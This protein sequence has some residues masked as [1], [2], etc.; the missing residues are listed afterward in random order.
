LDIFK[1]QP[2]LS[3]EVY[4][5]GYQYGRAG[6]PD[7]AKRFYQYVIDH[8]PE[9][10][11]AIA[12][13]IGLIDTQLAPDPRRDQGQIGQ[14]DKAFEALLEAISKA[15][16]SAKDIYELAMRYRD[17]WPAQAARLHRYNA[18]HSS[19]DDKYTLWSQVEL[20]K[21]Y[22]IDGNDVASQG[23]IDR[24]MGVYRDHPEL[25][26]ELCK[27]ANTYL[28][29]L[30]LDPND[31]VKSG[32]LQ[33]AKALYQYVLDHSSDP[34]V[35]RLWAKA[36]FI[37]LDIASGN[38][39]QVLE[40][41]DRLIAEYR[42][43]EDLSGLCV[44]MA[45]LLYKRCF[46][47]LDGGC[48]RSADIERA[49]NIYEWIFPI[50]SGDSRAR[51]LYG[52][53]TCHYQLGNY[54]QAVDRLKALTEHYPGFKQAA[55][56]YYRLAASYEALGHAGVLPVPE[57]ELQIEQAYAAVLEKEEGHS[58]LAGYAAIKLGRLYFRKSQWHDAVVAWELA[59]S[60]FS[61]RQEVLRLFV[62]D[63]ANCYDMLGDVRQ[64]VVWYRR[65]ANILD[66]YDPRLSKVKS[67]LKDLSGR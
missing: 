51:A 22:I 9:S 6:R 34:D 3:K 33:K 1:D 17:R 15:R 10:E 8:W 53:G 38:D 64:A 31:K 50:A 26:V 52:A 37:R 24:L 43:F 61:D 41:V 35:S 21:W 63:L 27:I 48:N 56:A 2:G 39:R 59:Y 65:A 54:N 36:G 40:Q 66:R 57:A 18:E 67:R 62:S 42:T 14:V 29:A 44:Q 12:S 23:A 58:D 13:Q 16:P 25:G 46:G 49:L 55:T 7:R 4:Q 20:A 32:Y 11:Y 45:D 47:R 19:K 5:I 60:R 28:E 30:A